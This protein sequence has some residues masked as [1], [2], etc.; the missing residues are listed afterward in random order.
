MDVEA[1]WPPT[2]TTNILSGS[3]NLCVVQGR[4]LRCKKLQLER[5]VSFESIMFRPAHKREGE[6]ITTGPVL[7]KASRASL[8]DGVHL[9]IRIQAVGYRIALGQA[10]F[11]QLRCWVR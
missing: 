1:F 5:V 4:R 3:D 6:D 10:G 2:T 8:K 9:G 11:C 7:W